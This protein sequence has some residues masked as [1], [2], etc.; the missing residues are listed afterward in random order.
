MA[1]AVILRAFAQDV[2]GFDKLQLRKRVLPA[3]HQKPNVTIHV[4]ADGR[5]PLHLAEIKLVGRVAYLRPFGKITLIIFGS[6][7]GLTLWL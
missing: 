4:H 6:I 5:K 7:A 3:N 2:V 1:F